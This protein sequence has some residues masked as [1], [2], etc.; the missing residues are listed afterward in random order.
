MQ[1]GL[2]SRTCAPDIANELLRL[3]HVLE[4]PSSSLPAVS[5]NG[6]SGGSKKAID[7]FS[8]RQIYPGDKRTHLRRL[9]NECGVSSEDTLFFDDETRNRNVE[10]LGVTFWL[11]EDGVTRDEVDKGIREWRRRRAMKGR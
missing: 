3:L 9:A 4:P 8:N 1:L 11:V 2:A 10:T 6:T 7:F 5:G